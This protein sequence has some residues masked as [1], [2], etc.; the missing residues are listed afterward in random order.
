MKL[1]EVER[2]SKTYKI[3]EVEVRAL[4]D[5]S[6][7]IEAGEF[8]AIMGPS[9]SGKSTLMHLLGFLDTPDSGNFRL[10]GK[11]TAHLKEE[12]YAFLRNRVIGFVF[13]QFNLMTRSTALEN[14]CLP[15]LYSENRVGDLQRSKEMLGKVGLADRVEHRPNE[16]SGGQQQRVAIARSLVNKPLMIL[17]DEPTGNLD[18]KSGREI[19]EIFKDLHKQGMTIVLVTHGEDV[20]NAAERVIRMHD[21]KI[22]SDERHVATGKRPAAE[23]KAPDLREF[24]TE[25]KYS[26]EEFQEHF[27]QAS[28][29]IL[30][31]KL[32]SFLSMLGV[33]IGVACVITMLALGRGAREAITEQLSRMGSNLLSIRPGSV[34]VHGVEGVAA[35]RLTFDDVRAIKEI[36]GVKEVGPQV[37]GQ[38][39]L[40]YGNKNWSTRVNGVTPEYAGMRNQEPVAGRFFTTGEDQGRERVVLIGKTVK[41]ALFGNEE[42]LGQTIK[43]NRVSFQVLGVLPSLG[44]NAFHDQ[45]DV[46]VIPL[47][48]AMKRLLGKDYVDQI[49]VEISDLKQMPVAQEEINQL[50]IRRHR[51]TPDRYDSFNIRN[52][53]DIQ[54]ALSSTTKTFGVLLGA[55]AAISLVVGGIGIMNIMLVSVKERTREIGLRKAL[56]ATPRD[57]LMQFLVEAVMITFLGGLAGIILAGVISWLI[58]TLA[59]WKMIITLDS[60]LLAFIFSAG[61]G[62]VFGLWPAKQA[63]ALDPIRALRYE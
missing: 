25:K 3:G 39:Q 62:I 55:V 40:V 20:A 21:G 51:L 36:P 47:M 35:T 61:V 16:L 24:S 29:V 42:P 34:K 1:L 41:E 8:V 7:T 6:L 63:A 38:G 57:I 32:R 52:Y 37:T 45:D 59:Q 26:L 33:L 15:L 27:K 31:N 48:T 54:A 43:I 5:V 46:V 14:V 11:D 18:S 4:Q 30:G 50:I 44:A 49:D 23:V 56:G 9:G 60:L 12:E 19:L 53:A 22:V 10:L 58:A 2:I 13:Q 17:A 28:R